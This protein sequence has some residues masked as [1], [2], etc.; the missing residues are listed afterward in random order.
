M[1]YH[2]KFYGEFNETYLNVHYNLTWDKA[3][4]HYNLKRI[5]NVIDVLLSFFHNRSLLALCVMGT[6]IEC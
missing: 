1:H 6:C 3:T 2:D 5:E 4:V